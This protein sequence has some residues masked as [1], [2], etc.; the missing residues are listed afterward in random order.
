MEINGIHSIA[1]VCSDKEKALDFYHKKL[2]LPIIRDNCKSSNPE[3]WKIDLFL[4]SGEL[5][6]FIKKNWKEID[7]YAYGVRHLSFQVDDVEQFVKELNFHG[8]ECETIRQDQFTG[9]K[10][11]VCY[12][13]DGLKLEFHEEA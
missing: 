2:G 6:I 8:I 4:G 7:H 11:A 3:H 9:E 5:E 12:D 13:P 1:I 10:I